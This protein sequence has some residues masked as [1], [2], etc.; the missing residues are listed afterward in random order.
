MGIS[1]CAHTRTHTTHTHTH[2]QTQTQTRLDRETDTQTQADWQIEC[3]G[4]QV[5]GESM[6]EIADK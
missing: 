5:C 1:R 4:D 3:F 6:V 2:T